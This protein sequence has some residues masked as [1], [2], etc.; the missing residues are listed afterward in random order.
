MI[1][2]GQSFILKPAH[3]AY[4]K[5][6]IL[7]RVE[8]AFVI[9]EKFYGRTF[10]RP[11]HIIF[12]RNGTKGG[13]CWYAKKE[14]M[15]QLDLAENNPDKF[16]STVD[17][18]VAHWID[19]EV[20][21]IQYNGTRHVGHGKTWK[22]IMSRVY[23]LNPDRYHS[24]DTSVTTT[25]KQTRHIYKCSCREHKVST[26][27]HNKIMRGYTYSCQCCGTRI[28]L[29]VTSAPIKPKTQLETIQDQIN[30]LKQQLGHV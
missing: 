29:D 27:V 16:F 3:N 26:T 24:Y 17:H 5:Q 18:E 15:F 20:Y 11:Q 10:T 13:H 12:K 23:G 30:K 28:A 1:G 8:Q 19:R 2:D 9:A 4:M 6:R 22:Y 25:K 7:D 14:L 21:G